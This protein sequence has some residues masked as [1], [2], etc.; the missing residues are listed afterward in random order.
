MRSVDAL[1]AGSQGGSFRRS[2]FKVYIQPP[3][4]VGGLTRRGPK[5]RQTLIGAQPIHTQRY[6]HVTLE[7]Q[8]ELGTYV[9]W[10]RAGL[11]LLNPRKW[12]VL[13]AELAPYIRE[14]YGPGNTSLGVLI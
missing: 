13:V 6:Q 10:E 1:S 14:G 3:N 2:I 8:V 11:A 9:R 7:L 4:Q 12:E 5:A